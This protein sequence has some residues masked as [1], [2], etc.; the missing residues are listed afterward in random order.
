MIYEKVVSIICDKFGLEES[1]VSKDTSFRQDLNADSL[2]MVELIMTLEEEFEIGEIA[3]AD[4][5]GINTVGDAVAYLEN[6][7]K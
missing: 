6:I 2:D 7:V 1:S 3:E 4:V 5:A